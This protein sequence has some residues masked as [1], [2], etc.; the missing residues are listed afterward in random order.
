LLGKHGK[1]EEARE[2]ELFEELLV[3]MNGV[4]RWSFGVIMERRMEERD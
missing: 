2:G 4:R 3:E 1:S